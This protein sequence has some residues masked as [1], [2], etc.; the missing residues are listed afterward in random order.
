MTLDI[1]AKL[2]HH[3]N[4]ELIKLLTHQIGMHANDLV[5]SIH[6]SILATVYQMKFRL[7]QTNGALVTYRMAKVSV[8]AEVTRHLIAIFNKHGHYQGIINM[9]NVLYNGDFSK[10]EK[11]LQERFGVSEE[12]ANRILVMST[13][14]T[15]SILGETIREKNLRMEGFREMINLKTPLY[16]EALSSG[17]NFPFEHWDSKSA[18]LQNQLFSAQNKRKRRT[19]KKP[20]FSLSIKWIFFLLL[21]ASILS[22]VYAY[23]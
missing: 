15:I 16:T 23:T 20:R 8:G 3:F 22:V 17:L 4:D 10:I 7:Q 5:A 12:I 11:M 18:E 13:C 19:E 9:T 6:F 21:S 14:G 2:N 1:K